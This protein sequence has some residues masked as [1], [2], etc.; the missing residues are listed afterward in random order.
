MKF[1]GAL[2]TEQ[3]VTFAIVIVKER[4]LNGSTTEKNETRHSFQ[5]FFPG[6]P[7]ILMAQDYRGIPSFYG[8][9]DIV[10]FLSNISIDRIPWKEYTV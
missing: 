3:R 2:I 7:I 4:I 8:R 5:R 9:R 10:D 6:V 1:Q